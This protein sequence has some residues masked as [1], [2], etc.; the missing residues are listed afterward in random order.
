MY[1]DT[2][3]DESTA[4]LEKVPKRLPRNCESEF[5]D[6]GSNSWY[7]RFVLASSTY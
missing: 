4:R 7:R 6:G 1:I 5:R 3:A 2:F